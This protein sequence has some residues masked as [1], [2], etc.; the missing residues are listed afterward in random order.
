M[1]SL[2]E[3]EVAT[4]YLGWHPARGIAQKVALG[5]R[6]GRRKHWLGFWGRG[7]GAVG[8]GTQVKPQ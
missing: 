1:G 5:P 3:Q 6:L 7:V 8:L 4:S 2:A